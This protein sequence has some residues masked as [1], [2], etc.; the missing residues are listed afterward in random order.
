MR[1]SCWRCRGPRWEIS[2]LG[3][4]MAATICVR[5]RPPGTAAGIALRSPHDFA[6]WAF[7]HRRAPLVEFLP[8]VKTRTWPIY[9]DTTIGSVRAIKLANSSSTQDGDMQSPSY[10]APTWLI[11]NG[12]VVTL[13]TLSVGWEASTKPGSGLQLD[14][15]A[16]L[17]K[18]G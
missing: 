16:K 1:S 12:A 17:L 7:H 10:R 15:V 4:Y 9:R 5:F 6:A 13:D 18:I 2:E 11:E 3:S 8:V 14:V